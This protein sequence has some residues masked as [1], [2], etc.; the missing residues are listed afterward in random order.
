METERNFYFGQILICLLKILF[1]VFDKY[2]HGTLLC[3]FWQAVMQQFCFHLGLLCAPS[4]S[5][6]QFFFRKAGS[7]SCYYS[8][9]AISHSPL[10]SK[11]FYIS[12]FE[13]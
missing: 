3:Q 9:F 2:N 4:L 1:L 11:I 8:I 13:R 10:E 7:S 12:Y 6:Q 5:I